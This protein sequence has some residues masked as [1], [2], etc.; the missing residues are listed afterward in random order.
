MVL[1]KQIADSLER[2]GPPAE[3]EQR[4]TDI[5]NV[6][7]QRRLDF[8]AK[9]VVEIDFTNHAD[10]LVEIALVFV[11]VKLAVERHQRIRIEHGLH[12]LHNVRHVCVLLQR[13][14]HGAAGRYECANAVQLRLRPHCAA[15]GLYK[16]R[17]TFEGIG[18]HGALGD[19]VHFGNVGAI[20]AAKLFFALRVAFQHGLAFAGGSVAL[21]DVLRLRRFPL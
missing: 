9:R 14:R 4:H 11:V 6:I 2:R 19:V 5:I 18:Q 10:Q 20:F 8:M 3:P 1:E 15:V 7:L 13:A 17:V 16:V 21:A 12:R